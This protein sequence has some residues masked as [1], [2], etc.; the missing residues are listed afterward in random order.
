[1]KIRV[2]FFIAILLACAACGKSGKPR[3][4]PE[5]EIEKPDTTVYPAK[6]TMLDSGHFSHK[7]ISI[8]GC[9]RVPGSFMYNDSNSSRFDLYARP[10][11]VR[12]KYISCSLPVGNGP[13]SMKILNDYFRPDDLV[14]FSHNGDTIRHGDFVKITGYYIDYGTSGGI[15][16]QKIEKIQPAFPEYSRLAAQALTLANYKDSALTGRLVYIDGLLELPYLAMTGEA[17][18][19]YLSVPGWK[20]KIDANIMIGNG[21]GQ[22]APLPYSFSESD[23]K[24]RNTKG[25]KIPLNKRVRLYGTWIPNADEY[26]SGTLHVEEMEL[27]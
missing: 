18:T 23:V 21:K 4:I 10:N 14:I 15:S 9:V 12:G 24:I 7:V 19:L 16:P 17:T 5:D 13:D 6:W 27:Q 3:E 1:M 20:E 8:T 22:M 11:Q 26:R 25:Q 2:C